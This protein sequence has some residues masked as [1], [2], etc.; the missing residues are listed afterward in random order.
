MCCGSA[1]GNGEGEMEDHQ[2]RR[3]ET[4]RC[5]AKTAVGVSED[6][7][8]KGWKEEEIEGHAYR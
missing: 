4:S 6:E 7:S 3:S 5:E 8:T 1:Y 2:G